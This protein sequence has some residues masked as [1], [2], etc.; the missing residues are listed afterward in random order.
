MFNKSGHNHDHC[1]ET[2]MQFA[3]DVCGERGARLTALRRRVL[4]LIWK[5][6]KPVGAYELLDFLK[7]ERRNAQPPTIYRTLDFL[8]EL[9]LVHRIESLNAFVGC[10]APDSAHPSQFLICRDCGS[11]SEISDKRLDKAIEGLAETAGFIVLQR[12]VEVAGYCPNCRRSG[13]E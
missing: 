8:L 5:S 9:G 13:H 7:N 2:A 11:A 4:E 12:I 10:C 6:H 1:V 3:V